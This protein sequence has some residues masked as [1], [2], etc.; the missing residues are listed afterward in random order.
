MKNLPSRSHWSAHIVINTNINP[1]CLRD[2][3][4]LCTDYSGRTLL[5]RRDDGVSVY[6]DVV[7]FIFQQIDYQGNFYHLV[8][9][10]NEE[11]PSISPA[12]RSSRAVALPLVIFA[13]KGVILM[14]GQS[15]VSSLYPANSHSLGFS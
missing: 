13:C 6:K 10:P 2:P 5:C 14:R 11:P 3:S 9:F 1:E 7:N 15:S 12:L 4:T 8:T